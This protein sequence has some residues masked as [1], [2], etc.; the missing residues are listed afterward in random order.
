MSATVWLGLTALAAAL[1]DQKSFALILAKQ[2]IST[3]AG[4]A[5][6]I[7]GI[8]ALVDYYRSRKA[9][10]MASPIVRDLAYDISGDNVA[11]AS[12]L[13]AGCKSVSSRVAQIDESTYGDSL[14]IPIER[15]RQDALN[16]IN[17]AIL[18]DMRRFVSAR[19][20]LRQGTRTRQNGF[21]RFAG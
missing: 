3:T 19:A 14:R 17:S 9:R 2:L 1:D 12:I 4:V 20:G 13:Y 8:G 21:D 11:L 7:L 16:R 6:A 5:F 10:Q 15:S 18:E